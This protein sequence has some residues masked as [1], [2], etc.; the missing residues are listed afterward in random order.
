M[1]EKI[2]RFMQGR[3]GTDPFSRFLS[4]FS[5]G[6]LLL[7]MLFSKLWGGIVSNIFYFVALFALGFSLFRSFSKNIYKRQDENRRYQQIAWKVKGWFLLQR[8]KFR[9][10]KD[11][12]YFRCPK[13]RMEMRVPRH[14]GKVQIRCKQCGESFLR[15]T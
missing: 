7:S 2:M 15:K 14:K 10:R 6:L 3:Y 11:Y 5:M 4:W 12:K 1:R 8:R 9:E 13:C